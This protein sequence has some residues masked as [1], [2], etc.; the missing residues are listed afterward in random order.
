MRWYK[1]QDMPG[2]PLGFE[3]EEWCRALCEAARERGNALPESTSDGRDVF[4]M[5]EVSLRTGPRSVVGPAHG[6][7]FV[8]LA[9]SAAISPSNLQGKMRVGGDGCD[10]PTNSF[11]RLCT[12]R[13]SLPSHF[14]P[15]SSNIFSSDQ[16]LSLSVSVRFLFFSLALRIIL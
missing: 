9:P 11:P 5:V 8:S 10:R 6:N 2:K 1:L 4:G 14:K 12:S 7:F 16:H 13:L 3:S 15:I